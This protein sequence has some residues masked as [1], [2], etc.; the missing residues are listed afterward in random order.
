[1]KKYIRKR[2]FT[3]LI[4]K[5]AGD[6]KNA[7]D[8]VLPINFLKEIFMNGFKTEQMRKLA[9]KAEQAKKNGTP[10]CEVFATVALETGLAKGSVR[11]A[12]YAAVKRAETDADFAAEIFGDAK[13]EV[14]KIIEFDQAEARVMLKRILVA[15][16]DGKSVRRSI[17]EIAPDPKTALR[18]Q[19]KYRNMIACERPVVEEVIA[20]IKAERGSCFDPYKKTGGDEMLA[21]LKREING[22][23]D[24]ISEN[25]RRENERLKIKISVLEEENARL[26]ERA[27]E[28]K[29]GVA[30][31]YFENV[32]SG[33]RR[34]IEFQK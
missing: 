14:T 19:N 21:R 1:M 18:Y 17:A 7:S 30:K 11:N 2:D 9:L 33:S 32:K 22:L 12:Y 25:L 34:K 6:N 16:S 15:V 20:E 4:I 23:Y 27:E 10:L 3:R 5:K 26:K 31:E 13:P 8:N 24:R 29:N 28:E